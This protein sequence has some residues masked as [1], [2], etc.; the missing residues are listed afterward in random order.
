MVMAAF[1]VLEIGENREGYWTGQ[2]FMEQVTK[3]VQIAEVKYPTSQGYHHNWCFDHIC[4]HTAYAEDALIASKMNKGPR[5]KTA[6]DE[7]HSLEQTT[8][9]NQ[10]ARRTTKG[11]GPC[12]RG[13]RL[14]HKRN[15]A[16]RHASNSS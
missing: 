14:Q 9:D 1:G 3:A 6:E 15:E 8:T 5:G 2:R 7:R 12:S 4:N 13:E 16:G 11:S 10:S